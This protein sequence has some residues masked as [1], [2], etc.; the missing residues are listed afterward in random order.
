[1]RHQ[2]QK[3]VEGAHARHATEKQ[4]SKS[5]MTAPQ[6]GARRLDASS[7]FSRTMHSRDG[8]G[9]GGGGGGVYRRTRRVI[10]S[11]GTE[12]ATCDQGSVDPQ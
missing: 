6:H 3:K 4:L 8:G 1:M 7:N 2:A 12:R 9:S 5:S 10:T 11:S